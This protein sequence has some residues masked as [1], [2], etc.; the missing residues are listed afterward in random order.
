MILIY[1]KPERYIMQLS[2]VNEALVDS[3]HMDYYTDK[4]G[5]M[6]GPKGNELKCRLTPDG[7]KTYGVWFE[8]GKVPVP[9][10]KMQAYQKF[11]NKMF[12]DGIQVRHL[13]GDPS[14]NSWDNIDI[15][16]ASDNMLDRDEYARKSHARTAAKA[17][18]NDIPDD[19]WEE[20]DRFQRLGCSYN[21]LNMVYGIA[22][23]TLSYRYSKTGKKQVMQN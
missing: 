3:D 7:Y 11:G 19:T 10:H 14:D 6:F 15:G 16:N 2:K 1:K 20:V 23:S 5:K 21:H 17:R 12:A 22:K 13:N 4:Q 9:V 18:K 8:G